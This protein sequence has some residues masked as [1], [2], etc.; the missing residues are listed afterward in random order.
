MGI[1]DF[2]EGTSIYFEVS[3]LFEEFLSEKGKPAALNATW[4]EMLECYDG[5]K[6]EQII[7]NMS[8]YW[9]GLQKNMVHK[10][11][12]EY[13]SA[14]S[15]EQILCEFGDDADAVCEALPQ[16]LAAEPIKPVRKPID[17]K[18]PG[19]KNWKAGD[20]YAYRLKGEE[21][22]K[23]GIKST[24]ALLYCH[25]VTK[26]TSRA[27]DV[28]LYLLH[29]PKKELLPTVEENIEKS[30][31][32]RIS[33]DNDYRYYLYDPHNAYPTDDLRYIGNIQFMSFP[34]DEHVFE[35][36][37]FYKYISWKHFESVICSKHALSLKSK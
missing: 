16:L 6:A 8:V 14:L 2:L 27:N 9:C 1:L 4:R 30:I 3:E 19:S 12:Y 11:S 35:S 29:Y 23:L 31:F 36:K 21:A 25:S 13:L 20:V 26:A 15:E 37:M 10:K 22:E 7:V 17:Y 24:Y 18:N 5:E 28:I 32:L 34:E 33:V